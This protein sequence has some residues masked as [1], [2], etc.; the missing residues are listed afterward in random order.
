VL[1]MGKRRTRLFERPEFAARPRPLHRPAGG[2]PP[3]LSRR[4][5]KSPVENRSS[6]RA[7]AKQS[8]S[9]A[10]ALDCFVAVAPRNDETMIGDKQTSRLPQAIEHRA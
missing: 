3:P 10:Q 1:M 6:L 9:L 5:M 8:S 7:S 4:R 2:P